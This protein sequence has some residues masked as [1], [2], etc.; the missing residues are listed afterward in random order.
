MG[1]IQSILT[2]K[3]AAQDETRAKPTKSMTWD[4]PGS[5]YTFFENLITM[6]GEDTEVTEKN[7]VSLDAWWRGVRVISDSISGLPVNIYQINQDGTIEERRDHI[8]YK[9]LNI[10]TSPAQGHF[11][12]KSGVID[13]TLN[14]GDSFSY[15]V[16][17]K[18]DRVKYLIPIWP[19][20]VSEWKID[21]KYNLSWKIQGIDGWVSDRDI[22]HIMG[23]SQ[24][25]GSSQ[26]ASFSG[27]WS[28]GVRR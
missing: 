5:L 28:Y 26:H 23:F 18:A 3:K 24:D 10:E 9:I 27:T 21:R 2:K 20:A 11:T 8:A 1:L 13:S 16:R 19:G 4:R 15:I 7:L 12:W 6:T 25:G 14:T 17:D 22:F